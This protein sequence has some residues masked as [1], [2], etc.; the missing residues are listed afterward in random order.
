M[1]IAIEKKRN[2]YNFF[3]DKLVLPTTNN[4]LS[5]IFLK[6]LKISASRFL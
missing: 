5:Y 1:V 3:I 2:Y 4:F 6:T